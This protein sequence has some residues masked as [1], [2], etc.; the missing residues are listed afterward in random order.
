MAAK[1][2]FSR[3]NDLANRNNRRVESENFQSHM[4]FLSTARYGSSAG[5]SPHRRTS[6]R[7]ANEFHHF[8]LPGALTLALVIM[9]VVGLRSLAT[10]NRPRPVP[11]FTASA[12]ASARPAQ[13][14]TSAP[15]GLDEWEAKAH[16]PEHVSHAPLDIDENPHAAR[17]SGD[18]H[19]SP[20]APVPPMTSTRNRAARYTGQLAGSVPVSAVDQWPEEIRW[21]IT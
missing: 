21:T 11:P 19:S 1:V 6:L 18:Q 10:I 8:S 7:S 15:D 20:A 12:T 9:F 4:T 16:R 5:A 2:V 3:S 13:H 17:P 14:A